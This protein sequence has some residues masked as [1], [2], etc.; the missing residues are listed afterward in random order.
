MIVYARSSYGEALSRLRKALT[1][2]SESLSTHVF[3]AVVLLCTYEVRMGDFLSVCYIRNLII[4]QLFTD[5]EN[6]ESWMKHAK[7]LGQ[8]IKARGPDHYRN[9]VDISLLKNSRGLIVSYSPNNSPIYIPFSLSSRFLQ[10][11][12]S[13]TRCSP[14]KIAS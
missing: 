1:N 4:R 3:C 6:P 10:W 12:R 13:C 9:E 14:G 2:P 5:T 8:L 11:S 7:G